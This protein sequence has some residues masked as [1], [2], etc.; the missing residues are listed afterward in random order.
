MSDLITYG[1]HALTQHGLATRVSFLWR[2]RAWKALYILKIRPKTERKRGDFGDLAESLGYSRSQGYKLTHLWP[3]IADVD[4]WAAI[5]ADQSKRRRNGIE[6]WPSDEAILVEF[7]SPLKPTPRAKEEREEAKREEEE[8]RARA[9]AK[10]NADGPNT[11]DPD[12]LATQVAALT[13]DLESERAA[14]QAV[15]RKL[16]RKQQIVEALN[17]ALEQKEA[18]VLPADPH[19]YARSLGPRLRLLAAVRPACLPC[20]PTTL[21]LLKQPQAEG[22]AIV[23][24]I[25]DID[26]IRDE[27]L[28]HLCA[29]DRHA[30]RAIERDIVAMRY[31][32]DAGLRWAAARDAIITVCGTEGEDKW[33][34]ANLHRSLRTLQGYVQLAREFQKYET[35]RLRLGPC[36]RSGIGFAL[37][38]LGR[39]VIGYGTRRGTAA[40][41]N[42]ITTIINVA[43]YVPEED[44]HLTPRPFFKGLNADFD[45]TIDLCA[46]SS[47]VA[48]LPNFYSPEQDAL[49]QIWLGRGFCNSPFARGSI[50]LWLGYGIASEAE[51]LMYLLPS[52]TGASWWHEKVLPHAV[53]ILFPRGRLRFGV[54]KQSAPFDVSL[55]MFGQQ[56]DDIIRRCVNYAEKHR[57]GL[58]IPHRPAIVA[59][60]RSA[61]RLV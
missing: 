44:L 8:A 37:E 33:C 1:R 32:A 10:S 23:R 43:D 46:S 21:T 60:R 7:P 13:H 5:K 54:N 4:A 55:V 3:I 25:D 29:G 41:E 31:Y 34:R 51:F 17:A 36:G 6:N 50:P 48:L 19:V 39:P 16:T 57:T 52:A 56:P 20:S 24:H 45:F 49:K 40:V 53:A 42:P 61:L 18:P 22:F 14:R 28:F 38:L 30:G 26:A 59:V 2:R 15:E 11:L 35:R 9:K 27:I 47:K 58:V 12:K